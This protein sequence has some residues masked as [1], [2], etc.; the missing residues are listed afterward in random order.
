MKKGLSMLLFVCLAGVALAQDFRVEIGDKT[1]KKAA[2]PNLIHIIE[3]AQEGKLL[4]LEP[5]IKALVGQKTNPVKAYKL[6]LCDMNWRDEKSVEITDTKNSVVQEAFRSG[7]TLHIILRY[8]DDDFLRVRHL[9][10]D[11]NTLSVSKDEDLFKEE[12]SKGE[13]WAWTAASPNGEFYGVVCSVTPK[14]EE[15]KAM[16]MLFDKDMKKLWSRKLSY[17]NVNQMVVNDEGVM[18]TLSS[19]SISGKDDVTAFRV[20]MA[21]AEGMLHGEFM[22][23]ADVDLV[24][25][26][27]CSDSTILAVAMEGRGNDDNRL[28][29]NVVS[30]VFNMEKDEVRVAASHTFTNAELKCLLNESGSPASDAIN[31]LR[32][33]E[34]C[35]TPQ[36]GAV[37]YQRSWM[38]TKMVKM[39]GGWTTTVTMHGKGMLLVRVDMNGKIVTNHIPMDYI[40]GKWPNIEL[41]N[42]G[43]RLYVM[44]NESKD[45][46]D[47]YNPDKLA[48]R[49]KLTIFANAALAAYWF[50]PEGRGDKRMVVRDEKAVLVS[51]VYHGNGN[52]FYCLTSGGLFPNL[53][54]IIL[55]TE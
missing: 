37:L 18:A 6:R 52:R 43:E 53:T 38:E 7:N 10:Y 5:K 15:G 2:L 27:N 36:G 50:T 24:N 55:P 9:A 25:L 8:S 48:E 29:K 39:N 19:G 41:F 51:D 30:L 42:H 32:T 31:Y 40:G 46:K 4:V 54:S 16:A 33:L 20:N 3:G 13:S 44:M 23:N 35:T 47:G 14:H 11:V 12:F 49:Q 17:N 28:Y 1:N 26:L 22:L 34:S 21:D 45:E